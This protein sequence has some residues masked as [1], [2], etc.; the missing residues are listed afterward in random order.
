LRDLLTDVPGVTTHDL[1]RT[2][3]AIVTAKVRGVPAE[4]VAAHLATPA[5]T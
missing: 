3:C 5:S 1:G 2:R 4:E